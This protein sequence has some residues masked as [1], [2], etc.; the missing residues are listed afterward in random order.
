MGFYGIFVV[1]FSMIFSFFPM[2][3]I[4]SFFEVEYTN[5][6]ET[7]QI[8]NMVDNND[9]DGQFFLGSGQVGKSIYYYYYYKTEFMGNT[10]KKHGKIIA[11]DCYIDEV[12]GCDNPRMEKYIPTLTQP[13]LIWFG[14]PIKDKKSIYK[15]VVPTGTIRNG[16]E[17][18][19]E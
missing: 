13:Y 4:G 8:Y 10:L 5:K 12:D 6:S 14:V 1:L 16:F 7:I 18:D 17:F 11:E 9:I 19:L 2:F 3:I 15:I